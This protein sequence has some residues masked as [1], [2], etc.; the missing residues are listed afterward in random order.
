MT[1]RAGIKAYSSYS[2]ERQPLPANKGR[3]GLCL[4]LTVAEE[5]PE[6]QGPSRFP[7][8]QVTH[9]AIAVTFGRVRAVSISGGVRR[10]VS[11]QALRIQW[12]HHL[13]SVL[14]A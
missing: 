13:F 11:R 8:L 5:D 6:D 3:P 10:V 1:R 2:G 12:L 4:L 14:T 9:H 7:A